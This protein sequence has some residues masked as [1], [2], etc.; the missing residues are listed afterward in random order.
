[1]STTITKKWYYDGELTDPT[2]IKLSDPTGTYGVRRKDTQAL[3]VADGATMIKID[4]GIYQYTFDDPAAD[5]IYEYYVEIVHDGETYYFEGTAIGGGGAALPADNALVTLAEIKDWLKLSG[6]GDNDFLVRAI[7][8]WSDTIEKRL[9]RVIKSAEHTDER[10]DGGK[11]AVLLKNM[12]VTAVSSLSVDGAALGSTDYTYDTD[13]GI[14]KLVSGNSF[15]GGPG[16][17]LVTYTGGYSTVPGDLVRAVKQLTAL[18]YYLSGHGRKAL[19]KRGESTGEGTATYERGPEDQER[20]LQK[21]ERKYA[22][23]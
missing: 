18:E 15:G 5:L 11:S 6:T 2:T 3:V 4:E 19:A 14:V 10:H 23:R 21:I 22:R 17:I 7:N 8:D 13:S 20:I 1:M 16:S 9:G 12:P